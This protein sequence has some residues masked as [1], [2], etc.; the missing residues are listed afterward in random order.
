[1]LV[2]LNSQKPGNSDFPIHLEL[3]GICVSI[4]TD[5]TDIQVETEDFFYI[6]DAIIAKPNHAQLIENL[7]K[8]RQF[9][10]KSFSSLCKDNFF[11]VI[12]D[13][14]QKCIHCLRDV[15]G[16]KSGYWGIINKTICV[17]NNVHEVAK[18]LEI[19]KFNDNAVYQTLYSGYLLNGDTIYN[20]VEE[21]KLGTHIQIDLNIFSA[22]IVATHKI[23]FAKKE[24][25][26]DLRAN[27]DLLRKGIVDAHQKY[28]CAKNKIL[29]SGGLDS[30]A[31]LVALDDL[32]E[33]DK[34]HCYSF[35]VKNTIQDETIYA[36]AAADFL[37]VKNTIVEIDPNDEK[38]YE[39]FETKILQMNN[40]YDGV[41][42]FGNFK[43]T[44]DDMY[45][46]G[47]DTRLHTPALS[48]EDKWAFGLAQ[49]N[50]NLLY[51]Y[52]AIPLMGLFKKFFKYLNFDVSLNRNLRG[53]AKFF[54]IFDI[55]DY[56]KTYHLKFNAK[57]AEK[58]GLDITHYHNYLNN[59]KIDFKRSSN[60]RDLY[61][62]IV[63][64]RWQQQYISDIRYLQDMARINKTYIAM[65][66]YNPTLAEF[67][68]SIPY[69]M[70]TKIFLGQA[71]H[72]DK[73]TLI[74]KYILR[75]SVR[76]KIPDKIYY[77]DKGGSQTCQLMYNGLL[78]KKVRQI[79]EQD[80]LS[81]DSFI[82]KYKLEK[83]VNIFMK[84][85]VWEIDSE[86]I[87][88]TC[89]Y[90]CAFCIYNKRVLTK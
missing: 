33:K 44:L 42:I 9:D 72:G 84:T 60:K 11:V 13:K 14:R 40:P 4:K 75:E 46:A 73:K 1:M 36:Q 88:L 59:F 71:E 85:E 34:I 70:A 24:N 26:Q 18:Q 50:Q 52:T 53:L 90:I 57:K 21:V 76:D 58:L 10:Y 81:S 19:K 77:R 67:S 29:L 66:F 28:L 63:A 41:W 22:G 32:T 51:R 56:I 79:F 68:S 38:I 31:M 8:L 82:K 74:N 15:S 61:N 87:L 69:D 3:D 27:I 54:S 23:N 89:H 86:D 45:Y 65:P 12:I 47:Q 80:L 83:I 55:D 16:V 7:I 5:E 39:D 62:Q 25:S 78:G 6:V 48:F 49:Y 20:D 30:V 35:K 17:G 2:S 43:G 37:H 64:V